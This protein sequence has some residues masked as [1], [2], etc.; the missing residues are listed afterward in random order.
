[1]GYCVTI[2]IDNIVIP[3]D[4]VA[5][6]LKSINKLH[7][8]Q[9]LNR[10]ASGG[11]SKGERWYSFTNLGNPPFED[12]V[13]AF[14]GWRY[15]AEQLENGDVILTEFNGEKLGD[16]V[17]LYQVIAP[18]VAGKGKIS[19]SGEDGG[20]WSYDFADGEMTSTDRFKKLE[21]L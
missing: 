19:I 21:L 20:K 2:E 16:D 8:P 12:L 13:E 17:Y 18:Y 3:S 9:N 14:D 4:K 7:E 5:E 6:A 1:M 15:E 10:Y 11:S